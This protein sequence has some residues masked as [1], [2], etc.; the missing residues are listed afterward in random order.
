MAST[1]RG[2]ILYVS[3]DAGAWGRE[4][5]H[6]TD[7]PD[8][9]KTVRTVS[10]LEPLDV[11]REVTVT[12]DRDF[13]PL[14]CVERLFERGDTAVGRFRFDGGALE[15]EAVVAGSEAVRRIEV[16]GRASY[17][18]PHPRWGD[19]WLAGYVDEGPPGRR[20]VEGY[21]GARLAGAA[22]G[23]WIGAGTLDV[24]EL[25]RERVETPAGVFET[26]RFR[27]HDEAGCQDVWVTDD[28]VFVRTRN[29]ALGVEGVLQEL[30]REP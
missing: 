25:P 13:R 24:E 20:T 11:I 12:V 29:E 21:L 26:R 1:T 23:P 10:E 6:R 3:D 2:Y 16:D 14:D 4:W 9:R 8:G 18:G 15:C 30:E 5:F 7:H 28:F 17:L 27:F 22:A 19:A